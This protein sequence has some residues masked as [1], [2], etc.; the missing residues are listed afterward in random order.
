MQIR[1]SAALF[2]FETAWAAI[3]VASIL[4]IAFYVT[5]ALIERLT[6]GWHPSAR[7]AE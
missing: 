3:I 5:I 7:A 1:N 2:N 6:M 4:G